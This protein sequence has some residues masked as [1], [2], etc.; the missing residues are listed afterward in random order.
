MTESRGD[1]TARGAPC[2][3]S[4]GPAQCQDKRRSSAQEPLDTAAWPSNSARYV[5]N[6]LCMC[7][8]VPVELI[9]PSRL[10]VGSGHT[11]CLPKFIEFSSACESLTAAFHAHMG[12][13]RTESSQQQLLGQ[14]G[15]ASTAQPLAAASG[16]ESRLHSERAAAMRPRLLPASGSTTG[17]LCPSA[18]PRAGRRSCRPPVCVA[19]VPCGSRQPRQARSARH[20]NIKRMRRAM[21]RTHHC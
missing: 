15:R 7:A 9:A 20:A 19:G 3:A 12:S 14:G 2:D 5:T 8:W 21:F 6:A 10:G 18:P 1:K 17:R 13:A 4:Y 16:L 11:Y